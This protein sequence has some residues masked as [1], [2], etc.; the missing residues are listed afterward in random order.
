MDAS[1]AAYEQWRT[2]D[3]MAGAAESAL[4]AAL[5]AA[6]S[7]GAVPSLQERQRVRELRRL[8]DALMSDMFPPL[9]PPPPELAAGPAA[10]NDGANDQRASAAPPPRFSCAPR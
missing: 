2:A 4:F 3:R 6:A 7:G 1:S 5:L 10:V 8:A 9:K